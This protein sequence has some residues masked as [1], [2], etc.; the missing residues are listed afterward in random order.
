MIGLT[1]SVTET[2][3][4]TVLTKCEPNSGARLKVALHWGRGK[5]RQ[6]RGCCPAGIEY[7]MD[8][9]RSAASPGS[10]GSAGRAW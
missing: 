2:T 10:V 5:S 7:P 4:V 8:L 3:T 6:L 1:V 9:L